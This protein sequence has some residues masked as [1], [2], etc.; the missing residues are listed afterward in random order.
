MVRNLSQKRRHLKEDEV[1]Q[2]IRAEEE[3]KAQ[4]IHDAET[5]KKIRLE[6]RERARE[7]GYFRRMI[8]KAWKEFGI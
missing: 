7:G 6:E 3:A 1:R 4:K 8:K 5:I 2:K